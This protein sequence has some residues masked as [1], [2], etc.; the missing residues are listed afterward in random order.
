VGLSSCLF[1]LW[2]CSE[3][4]F[5]IDF[6]NAL[7]WAAVYCIAK[8]SLHSSWPF[9]SS[10]LPPPK[11]A[12]AEA[13]WDLPHLGSYLRTPGTGPLINKGNWWLRFE[14]HWSD[15][16]HFSIWVWFFIHLCPL[17]LVQ[18]GSMGVI[19][20]RLWAGLLQHRDLCIWLFQLP[21]T[22]QHLRDGWDQW[23]SWNA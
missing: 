5:G 21:C 10:V 17:W 20:R 19:G 23:C 22:V 1:L 6:S 18:D 9:H 4:E 14:Q 13:R 3:R 15:W 12:S 16:L 11:M 8:L 2:G 7:S